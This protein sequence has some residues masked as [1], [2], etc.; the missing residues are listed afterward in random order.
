MEATDVTQ[1]LPEAITD[2][3]LLLHLRVD[4]EMVSV[5]SLSNDS[6]SNLLLCAALWKSKV[7]LEVCLRIE[8]IDDW[9]IKRRLI[10]FYIRDSLCTGSAS[11]DIG[12][13]DSCDKAEE[14]VFF[15]CKVELDALV[16]VL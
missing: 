3:S 4:E 13:I 6:L 10:E 8:W 15:C 11:N 1:R 12:L 5:P 16:D 7:A 9:I 2:S 14:V